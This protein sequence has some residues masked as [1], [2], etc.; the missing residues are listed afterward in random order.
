MIY[1]PRLWIP[2]LYKVCHTGRRPSE[3]VLAGAL[4]YMLIVEFAGIFSPRR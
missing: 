3:V 1:Y 4:L 2:K